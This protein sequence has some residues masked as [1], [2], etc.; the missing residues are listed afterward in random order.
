MLNCV[1]G[2]V[3]SGAFEDRRLRMFF[4]H[5]LGV[6]VLFV[7]L[8]LIWAMNG[9]GL[10]YSNAVS[11][12]VVSAVVCGDTLLV[13]LHI[14]WIGVLKKRGSRMLFPLIWFVVSTVGDFFVLLCCGS[15]TAQIFQSL[16]ASGS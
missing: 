8:A 6:I 7:V 12:A 15:F 3:I 5:A 9:N 14:K 1:G 16:S 13:W 10:R 11:L 2:N 4:V